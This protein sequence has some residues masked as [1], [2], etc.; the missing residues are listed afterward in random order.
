M[1]L[2]LRSD[3]ADSLRRPICSSFARATQSV[4]LV[5]SILSTERGWFMCTWALFPF[6]SVFPRHV[7]MSSFASLSDIKPD[8]LMIDKTV[9]YNESIF[10]IDSSSAVLFD[11]SSL[12]AAEQLATVWSLTATGTKGYLAPE[13]WGD[14][15]TSQG[16]S[17][18]ADI[19]SAGCSLRALLLRDPQGSWDDPRLADI[20][21]ELRNLLSRM[22][23]ETPLE[24]PTTQELLSSPLL[25][26]AKPETAAKMLNSAFANWRL[27]EQK[28]T[29]AGEAEHIL[30]G[31][32]ALKTVAAGLSLHPPVAQK[33]DEDNKEILIDEVDDAAEDIDDAAEEVD[34]ADEVNDDDGD[35]D[36]VVE[37][38]LTPDE[39]K[40]ALYMTAKKLEEAARIRSIQPKKAKKAK[41]KYPEDDADI[42]E[43]VAH[44]VKFV[45]VLVEAGPVQLSHLRL[46]FTHLLPC[47]DHRRSTK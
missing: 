14:L 16:I 17:K 2:P 15:R 28:M 45:R 31:S 40:I 43:R 20:T 32:L 18:L 5:R 29:A 9:P 47:L 25:A 23:S 10:L 36:G 13:I 22:T 34:D 38:P 7:L 30:D 33:L 12:S 19:Y 8:N 3:E 44:T 41:S 4:S 42:G 37:Q 11:N 21:P 46:A 6:L 35:G 39:E 27:S 26:A 24:R 1:L